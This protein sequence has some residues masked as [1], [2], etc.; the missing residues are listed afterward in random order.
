MAILPLWGAACG[1]GAGPK[2][3]PPVEG[4]VIEIDID[5]HGLAGLWMANAPNIKGLIARGTLAFSR[6]IV[7]THSNQ[8]NMALLTGQYPEGHDVPANSWL[9]RA[10][11]FTSPLNLPGL[12]VG[13]YAFYMVNPLLNR[14]DSVYGATRRVGGTSAYVGELPT[15]E[16]GADDVH[17]SI[18]GL[19]VGSLTVTAEVGRELL[20]DGLHYPSATVKGYHFDG[21]PDPGESYTHFT[22]RDAAAFVRATSAS[23]PMPNFMFVWD[24]LALDS[25][26]TGTY[27]AD[28]PALVAVI[29]DY[30]AAL[31]ELLTALSDKGLLDGTNILFTLDH[32][33]VDTH[34][35]VALGTRGGASATMPADGQLAAAV[36]AQG[37]ALGISTADYALLNEDG[38]AQ[39]YA[40]VTDAGTPAGAARQAAVTSALLTIIQSG[41]IVGL[42]TTRTMTADGALGT[43]RFQDFRAAGPNQA[44]IVVFPLDDWTLNQVDPV[45][46]LPGPFRE[47]T[48]FPYGRHGGF[49]V[50]ELYVPLI[51]AGPA[52]K[53]GQYLPHPVEHPQVA[54]TAVGLLGGARI[55][56]AAWGPLSP[57][58][59]GDPGEALPL[60][61]ASS[62]TRGTVLS[63]SGF[64]GTPTLA[65]PPAKSAIIVDVAGLYE[66][67]LFGDADLVDEA[68][69]FAA[70]TARGICFEDF[71]TQS[72]DWPVTEYQSL[73]GG[74]PT[75]TLDIAPAE[76]DPAQLTPP[77]I[78]LLKMPVVPG[79]IAN[80]AGY[81]AWRQPTPFGGESL[82][83]AAHRLGLTT[84]LVGQPDFHASHL[85][86]GAIDQLLPADLGTVAGAIGT[87]LAAQP[88]VLAVVALGGPRTADRH[89]AAARGE[90]TALSVT[91]A[92]IV[93][94]ASG[95]LVVITSRGATTIDD[96]GAD[97]YGAG[98]SRHVPLLLLGPNV[99]PAVIS[100]QP[101][102]PVDLPATV[103]FG[104]GAPMTT[105][106][107]NGT[108]ATGTPVNGVPHPLPAQATA[109][110][111]LVRAFQVAPTP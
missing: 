32:G 35:Q 12:E 92:N 16:A 18:L 17:L 84:A 39:V 59:L 40:R 23:N 20:V 71:W 100:G 38:D 4:H 51:M 50:D 60:P 15:F 88:G 19:P 44:D 13:D 48:A 83:D 57:A 108:W 85:A 66:Q 104:L 43:R 72:R 68:A 25:D 82:F 101:G 74:M 91:I 2:K 64:A 41:A 102:S 62:L 10:D 56:T 33:K 27:G 9:S 80:Q 99:R 21:P 55:S 3:G 49:S 6:V 22:L 65:G 90:L 105:D 96:P 31:G 69:P 111:A 5:D 73:V 24:F 8:N 77:G 70:L 94:A 58:L 109:G 52:F 26:P 87:L 97:F 76:T 93:D 14:G 63:M 75:L 36:A 46:A 110:R 79:F 47:H 81:Q 1:G 98:T 95:A 107:A 7:P 61:D 89:S 42:D 54:S 53:Q 45:N 103:L 86:A 78:G 28:G 29:E 34:D 37:P 67:E 11:S 30:D 106:F